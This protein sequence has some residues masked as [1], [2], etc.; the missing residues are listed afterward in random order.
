MMN[1]KATYVAYREILDNAAQTKGKIT[2]DAISKPKTIVEAMETFFG[3]FKP[4]TKEAILN[5][6]DFDNFKKI[7]EK[8]NAMP[9]DSNSPNFDTPKELEEVRVEVADYKSKQ[10]TI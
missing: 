3:L 9:Y 2:N 5:E 4:A 8:K 7:V 1:V 10:K 6:V